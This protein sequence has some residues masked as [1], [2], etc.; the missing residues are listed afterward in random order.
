MTPGDGPIAVVPAMD[1]ITG[2]QTARILA[3]RGVPVI[4][5]VADRR[6]FCAR[7][8]VIRGL[9]ESPTAG[10]PLIQSLERLAP[11]L[12]GRPAVLMPCSDA[13]VLAISRW[14]DRLE[15]AYRFVLPGH[16]IV[17]MLMDKV[18]F[19]EYATAVGLPIPTTRILRSAADARAAAAELTFPAVLKP[20][21]KSDRWFAATKAK[22]IR[23]DTAADLISA[24]DRWARA[25]DVL[26]AQRW[27]EGDE[28]SL[29]SVNLYLDRTCTA[30][31]VFVARKL[32]QWPPDTGTSSLGEEVRDD[33][34]RDT[35]IRLFERAGFRG[36]AYLEMK[37]DSRTGER[38][39]V[40]P[41]IGRPTGRSAIAEQGGVELVYSAFLDALGEPLPRDT[42]QRYGGARWIYWR[43][44]LQAA[45]VHM[46]SGQLTPAAWWRSVRGPKWEA[47]YDPG[48]PRPFI[49]D[50]LDTVGKSARAV[51]GRVMHG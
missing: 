37:V 32:R 43:H 27:I 31:V 14:R 28:S 30:R 51:R 8:R 39:I 34:V 40:E 45:A 19:A 44:D 35:A 21:V 1:C 12:G 47:V 23:I 16:D 50:V 49:T 17:E 4:G 29:V 2:L 22:A 18:R 26:I 20:S 9:V 10:E 13:A 7:T 42:E 38:L 46:V 25:T 33:A 48:D 6:H 3:A 11:R 36:L 5:V 41:N 15:D 24:Y